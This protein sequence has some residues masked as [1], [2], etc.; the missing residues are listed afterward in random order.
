MKLPVK[1]KRKLVDVYRRAIN[2]RA[3]VSA[4]AK[5]QIEA[6]EQQLKG[7]GSFHSADIKWTAIN[8]RAFL[9]GT[10]KMQ[11]GEYKVQT[12]RKMDS[13]EKIIAMAFSPVGNT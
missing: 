6:L 8:G 5:R 3:P 10:V 11:L 7:W 13:T 1:I 9:T 4:E 2:S 12:P